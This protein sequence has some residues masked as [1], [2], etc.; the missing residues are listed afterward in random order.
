MT[1]SDDR[2]F[3]KVPSPVPTSWVGGGGP[4]TRPT[5]A[6]RAWALGIALCAGTLATTASGAV[7]VTKLTGSD[8]G[9]IALSGARLVAGNGVGSVSLFERE[10][11]GGWVERERISAPEVAEEDD[12]FLDYFANT[13]AIEGERLLV[14]A[15][16]SYFG[17]L[18][19]RD[20]AGVWTERARL[21]PSE[22]AGTAIFG[23]DVVFSSDVA[24]SGD[25]L[26]ITA[27]PEDAAFVFER[28]AEGN[29]AETAKLVPD[30][31]DTLIFYPF[32]ESVALEGD[33]LVVGAVIEA[34]PEGS[35]LYSHAVYVF[36]RD[37]AGRWGQ[38]AKLSPPGEGGLDRNGVSVG[39]SGDR[40]VA[41]I[42]TQE[43]SAY[44]YE[45]RD[46]GS[47]TS[48][49]TLTPTLLPRTF[50]RDGD[51]FE[52]MTIDL[53]GDRVVMGGYNTYGGT[54]PGSVFVFERDGAGSWT[55]VERLRSPDSSP[56]DQFGSAISL[57]GDGLVVG[58]G[59]RG[60][61]GIHDGAEL[62]RSGPGSTY[63]FDLFGNG[64]PSVEYLNDTNIS[65]SLGRGMPA[66]PFANRSTADSLASVI[67]ADSAGDHEFDAQST[68][69][70]VSGGQLE[71][72]FDFP[73]ARDLSGFHF[74][75][76][77]G[78]GHD[79]DHIVL[80]LFDPSGALL[81]SETIADP[82]LGIGGPVAGAIY[83]ESFA[84]SVDGVRSVRALLSGSNDQ[85]N[86]QNIGFTGVAASE[87]PSDN[88][89]VPLPVVSSDVL[90]WSAVPATSINVH[91]GDGGY[92][93]T[94]PGDATS[95][96][97]PASGDYYLVATNEG[98]WRT[99]ARSQT[100]TA[101]VLGGRTGSVA[102]EPTVA[103]DVLSWAAVPATSINV[104]D[105]DGG[106]LRTLPGDATWWIAPRPPATIT[107]WRPTRRTGAPGHAREP[108]PPSSQEGWHR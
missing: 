91:D 8:G 72:R 24:L 22:N 63:V 58:A 43:D 105:G 30:D 55:E 1:K 78:E 6:A 81:S 39:L 70:R 90:I 65:V 77:T 47:W 68:H 101:T 46:D 89:T 80:E 59:E 14:S 108:P 67:D 100:V 17:Y 66:E 48:A 13:V 25:R 36:E 21:A 53:D 79:V 56:G 74:W 60:V 12:Y 49:A 69:V 16:G 34:P 7:E 83:A 51:G 73:V 94:L 61:L 84:L 98:D 2:V 38:T 95:W 64:D 99:W 88:A 37:A 92:L 33:R 45:R 85:V 20:A 44:V 32:G 86:F 62:F 5:R 4:R 54:A 75:N 15:S 18:F 29:W 27:W 102:P 82:A 87:E 35:E 10:A 19:E 52:A 40:I 42:D 96:A 106:Y 11:S 41:G 103:G 50:G 57:D 9:P 76:A 28:T 107:S 31:R 71:L 26:A 97:A 3:T 23:P 93:R 104:H